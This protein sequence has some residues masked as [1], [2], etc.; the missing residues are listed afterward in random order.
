MLPGEVPLP[1]PV[2]NE[3]PVVIARPRR[4]QPNNR[5]VN[6]RIIVRLPLRNNEPAMMQPVWL[7]DAAP[8]EPER[9]A[10]SRCLSNERLHHRI[11]DGN[12]NTL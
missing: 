3:I 12:F 11:G 5:R 9:N 7:V 1:L 10:E 4:N 2:Q 8:A 6:N